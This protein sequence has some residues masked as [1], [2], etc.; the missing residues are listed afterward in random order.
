MRRNFVYH[1][2]DSGKQYRRNN[3]RLDNDWWHYFGRT[4]YLDNYRNRRRNLPSCHHRKRL[5]F[6]RNRNRNRRYKP[7]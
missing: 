4:K 5:F 2:R 7:A 3:L 1:F 6:Y